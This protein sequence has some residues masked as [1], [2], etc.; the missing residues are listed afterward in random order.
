[1]NRRPS[2]GSNQ[3]GLPATDPAP[4]AVPGVAR[5]SV[6]SPPPV[7]PQLYSSAIWNPSAPSMAGPAAAPNSAPGNNAVGTMDLSSALSSFGPLSPGAYLNL[8]PT[9][10]P[11]A[12]DLSELLE[13]FASVTPENNGEGGSV[14]YFHPGAIFNF[15]MPGLRQLPNATQGNNAG[16]GVDSFPSTNPPSTNSNNHPSAFPMLA[17]SSSNPGEGRTH[18]SAPNFLDW[19][20]LFAFR[21]RDSPVA[22][23]FDSEP[24]TSLSPPGRTARG[25]TGARARRAQP[26]RQP[27]IRA[28]CDACYRAKVKCSKARPLCTRCISHGLDCKYSPSAKPARNRPNVHVPDIPHGTAQQGNVATGPAPLPQL[29]CGLAESY[30][31]TVRTY[32]DGAN[33]HSTA[34]TDGYTPPESENGGMSR[35]HSSMGGDLTTN[36]YVALPQAFSS[37][38]IADT[39]RSF[40]Y[41]TDPP[42][43]LT[44]A[45]YPTGHV[46]PPGHPIP[47]QQQ[48]L[49]ESSALSMPAHCGCSATQ[50][51]NIRRLDEATLPVHLDPLNFVICTL[52]TCVEICLIPCGYCQHHPSPSAPVRVLG[53]VLM[54]VLSLYKKVAW[55]HLEVRNSGDGSVQNGWSRITTDYG[56]H[57]L[58]TQGVRIWELDQATITNDLSLLNTLFTM[59]RDRCTTVAGHDDA[60]AGMATNVQALFLSAIQDV[61]MTAINGRQWEPFTDPPPRLWDRKATR[62]WATSSPTLAN[63]THFL[64]GERG[65]PPS[66]Q[67]CLFASFALLDLICVGST[68]HGSAGKSGVSG[69]LAFQECLWED[70]GHVGNVKTAKC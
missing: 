50:L 44:A 53:D 61:R 40:L 68:V 64:C 62:C 49:V 51:D 70:M 25:S 29:G 16:G 12:P 66:T 23:P 47:Q 30:P 20:N 60:L 43:V 17:G 24:Q 6:P 32:H 42:A 54:A 65:D 34:E 37:M 5:E 41:G 31:M 56:W 28:S 55:A 3:L 58:T 15:S 48:L 2:S 63:R 1:M 33:A 67:S 19:T 21:G 9:P 13:A 52:R 59:F 27:R 18:Q 39:P 57:T 45:G 35:T 36:Y 69:N 22:S 8:P 46:P 7:A 11:S 26:V 4:F 10:S 14:D 38:S